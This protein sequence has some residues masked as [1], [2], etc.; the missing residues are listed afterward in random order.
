MPMKRLVKL[1]LSGKSSKL[2]DCT[3]FEI[4]KEE[5]DMVFGGFREYKPPIYDPEQQE[6]RQ[7]KTTELLS[8]ISQP[9]IKS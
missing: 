6:N 5:S 9:N 3:S 4:K 2:S 7:F 1:I 8:D